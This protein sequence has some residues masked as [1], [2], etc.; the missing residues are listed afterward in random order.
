MICSIMMKPKLKNTQ[1]KGV[2]HGRH[3]NKYKRNQKSFFV[4]PKPTNEDYHVCKA[5]DK[6]A[7]ALHGYADSDKSYVYYEMRVDGKGAM[8]IGLTLKGNHKDELKKI[9]ENAKKNLEGEVE[10]FKIFA[11]ENLR[12]GLEAE[13]L[14]QLAGS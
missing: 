6:I 1:K 5:F 9:L 11:C 13:T 3:S 2:N 12:K 8:L 4:V 14:E 10:T 7:D